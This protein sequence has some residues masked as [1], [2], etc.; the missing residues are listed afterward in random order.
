MSTPS[1]LFVRCFADGDEGGLVDEWP[2][3][4]GAEEL[5][6]IAPGALQGEIVALDPSLVE[7]LTG[8]ALET[9]SEPVSFFVEPEQIK[10]E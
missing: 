2:V 1:R 8:R 4:L 6:A 3:V 9:Y 5:R 7:K 10:I